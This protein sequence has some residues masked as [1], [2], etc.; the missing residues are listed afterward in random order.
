Q[1]FAVRNEIKAVLGDA[2]IRHRSSQDERLRFEGLLCGPLHVRRQGSIADFFVALLP[3]PD[4]ALAR[5]QSHHLDCMKI[6]NPALDGDE[7]TAVEPTSAPCDDRCR[8]GGIPLWILGA[9]FEARKI[10]ATPVLEGV[11]LLDHGESVS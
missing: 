8:D 5:L 10:F 1:R 7:T 2:T 9:V 4:G 6:V 3:S 11:D